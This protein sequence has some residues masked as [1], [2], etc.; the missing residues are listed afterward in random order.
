MI[1]RG[2]QS[3]MTALREDGLWKDS[4]DSLRYNGNPVA[5]RQPTRNKSP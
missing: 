5:D 2:N 3:L 4:I 1:A